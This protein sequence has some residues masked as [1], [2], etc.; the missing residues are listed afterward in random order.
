MNIAL[1]N[2]ANWSILIRD[3]P[4]SGLRSVIYSFAKTRSIVFESEGGGVGCR[5]IQKVLTG[6]KKKTTSQNHG[7][8]NGVR[9]AYTYKTS[10]SLFYK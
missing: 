9:V 4:V 5:L 6:K 2:E 3:T 10:I 8:R 1:C 7:Y